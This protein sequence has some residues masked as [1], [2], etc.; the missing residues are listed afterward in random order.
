MARGRKPIN[1]KAMT[2]AERQQRRRDKY[3]GA[4]PP[5]GSEARFRLELYWWVR[6][7]AWFYSDLDAEVI[8]RALDE[9]GTAIRL[10]AY[11]V[12]EGGRAL[13]KQQGW[14]GD[15]RRFIH[16]YLNGKRPSWSD[17]PRPMGVAVTAAWE[18]LEP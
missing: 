2:A 8:Y 16:N 10:D 6:E 13:A 5:A 4:M 3:K 17:S 12:S 14:E 11:V 18:R 9:L 1:G 7:Q 15:Q